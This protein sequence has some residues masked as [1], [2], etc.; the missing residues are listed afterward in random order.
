MPEFDE[1]GNPLV[2]VGCP[3]CGKGKGK[4]MG[5][6]EYAAACNSG[7]DPSGPCSRRCKLQLEYA[8]ELERQRSANA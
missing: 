3:N 4:T 1:L 7:R 5:V 8:A 2:E 6:I